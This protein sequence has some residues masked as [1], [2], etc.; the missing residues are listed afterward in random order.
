MTDEVWGIESQC[1]L[2]RQAWLLWIMRY[3]LVELGIK[4]EGGY[5]DYERSQTSAVPAD[6]TAEN[7]WEET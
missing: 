2:G 1:E 7:N 5:R 4:D 6:E 3:G